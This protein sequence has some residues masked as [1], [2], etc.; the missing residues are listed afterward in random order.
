MEF[1][2]DNTNNLIV[3][4]FTSTEYKEK[5][6]TFKQF[7]LH[8]YEDFCYEDRLLFNQACA[9]LLKNTLAKENDVIK[10]K[11]FDD[12]EKF[13]YN[14]INEKDPKNIKSRLRKRKIADKNSISLIEFYTQIYC[15]KKKKKKKKKKVVC[16]LS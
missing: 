8:V 2:I 10:K 1:N 13:L 4:N 14:F 16:S 5:Y 11:G 6:I 3:R 7:L 15:S 12:I 9:D